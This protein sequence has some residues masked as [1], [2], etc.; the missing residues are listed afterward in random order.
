MII[1]PMYVRGLV[2][3]FL[4]GCPRQHLVKKRGTVSNLVVT[5]RSN[6]TFFYAVGEGHD[7]RL[8]FALSNG[9]KCGCCSIALWLC[10]LHSLSIICIA[11]IM[12]VSGACACIFVWAHKDSSQFN[13]IFNLHVLH[14]N[15]FQLKK[16]TNKQTHKPNVEYEC[17]IRREDNIKTTRRK[18]RQ[19][20]NSNDKLYTPT[21]SLSILH[22]LSLNCY[23]FTAASLK[24]LNIQ[25]NSI[26]FRWNQNIPEFKFKKKWFSY[27]K[28]QNPTIRFNWH[29]E[30]E[31]WAYK[32]RICGKK[33]EQFPIE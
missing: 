22:I 2:C 32:L 5:M 9:F 10:S 26:R 21:L 19:R 15:N 6:R 16:K 24:W 4:F 28:C 17:A 25:R 31:M 30:C 8:P 3:N 1:T 20:E 29:M 27:Q 23:Y 14:E 7:C 13:L 12:H 18:I 33:I 11:Y